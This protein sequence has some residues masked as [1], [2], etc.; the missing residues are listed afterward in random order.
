M[1]RQPSTANHSMCASDKYS[2]VFGNKCENEQHTAQCTIQVVHLT[3]YL[4]KIAY[5]VDQTSGFDAIP[6]TILLDSGCIQ[7]T[8]KE[9]VQQHKT[10]VVVCFVLFCFVCLLIHDKREREN[11]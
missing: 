8:K 6:T 3:V 1:N 2:K 11:Y 10:K 9:N 4:L 5:A 7:L